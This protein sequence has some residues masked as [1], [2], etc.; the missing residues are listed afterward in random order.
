MWM[1]DFWAFW[2]YIWITWTQQFHRELWDLKLI[3]TFLPNPN[4]ETPSPP[5]W[6]V[7]SANPTQHCVTVCMCTVLGNDKGTDY[8]FDNWE[9]EFMTIIVTI[10]S[11]TGQHSQFSRCFKFWRL[12]LLMPAIDHGRIGE[13]TKMDSSTTCLSPLIHSNMQSAQKLKLFSVFWIVDNDDDAKWNSDWKV[14][15]LSC[16][17][18]NIG[19]NQNE[20]KTVFCWMDWNQSIPVDNGDDDIQRKLLVSF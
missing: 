15:L 3:T 14:I 2:R 6:V 1:L 11:D 10:K 18:Q 16:K 9:P 13:A 5:S 7:E 8:N 12:R 20:S 19:I 17:T 4:M